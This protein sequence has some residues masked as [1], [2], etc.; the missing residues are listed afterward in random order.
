MV[1][2]FSLIWPLM[3]S[4]TYMSHLKQRKGDYHSLRSV[5]VSW[6]DVICSGIYMG[7]LVVLMEGASCTLVKD[8]TYSVVIA[9]PS[10]RCYTGLHIS[11]VVCSMVGITSFTSLVLF[12]PL[13]L[14][15][16][17]AEVV[18]NYDF[19]WLIGMFQ[20]FLPMLCLLVPLQNQSI[21][22]RLVAS[23]VTEVLFIWLF[24]S[25]SPCNILQVN[26]MGLAGFTFLL[27]VSVV[28]VYYEISRD[29]K[30]ASFTMLAASILVV[31]FSMFQRAF[32]PFVAVV[33][34]KENADGSVNNYVN[35]SSFLGKI[36]RNWFS[37]CLVI[38]NSALWVGFILGLFSFFTIHVGLLVNFVAFICAT[39]K[40]W[41]VLCKITSN[42]KGTK[43]LNSKDEAPLE[44]QRC[45]TLSD[46]RRALTAAVSRTVSA[47]KKHTSAPM[48]ASESANACKLYCCGAIRSIFNLVWNDSESIITTVYLTTFW[49]G[50]L[51]IAFTPSMTFPQYTGSWSLFSKALRFACLF[52]FPW[53]V[54]SWEFTLQ[55]IICA[56]LAAHFTYLR[57]P[58]Y[59][60][61]LSLS[62]SLQPGGML[63]HVS[64]FLDCCTRVCY[65]GILNT[66]G[67]AV[68]AFGESENSTVPQSNEAQRIS[69]AITGMLGICL[70]SGAFVLTMPLFMLTT[71]PGAVSVHLKADFLFCSGI[72]QTGMVIFISVFLSWQPFV[73]PVAS[74]VANFFIFALVWR[75]AP[76][77]NNAAVNRVLLVA[78]AISSCIS[79]CVCF[80]FITGQSD[81]ALIAALAFTATVLVLFGLMIYSGECQFDWELLFN[82][83]WSLFCHKQSALFAT[84]LFHT[85]HKEKVEVKGSS[86]GINPLTKTEHN[87][88]AQHSGQDLQ[89]GLVREDKSKTWISTYPGSQTEEMKNAFTAYKHLRLARDT[90]ENFSAFM[91]QFG[92]RVAVVYS[93][94]CAAFW[95]AGVVPVL[96]FSPPKTRSII[97]IVF[98]GVFFMIGMTQLYST[99]NQKVVWMGGD[100][101][102]GIVEIIPSMPKASAGV[103]ADHNGNEN[104]NT[105]RRKIMR[106][107]Q[108]SGKSCLSWCTF[109]KRIQIEFTN[110]KG[111]WDYDLGVPLGVVKIDAPP[112]ELVTG[113]VFLF[114]ANVMMLCILAHDRCIAIGGSQIRGYV[115]SCGLFA[116]YACLF[117]YTVLKWISMVKEETFEKTKLDLVFPLEKHEGGE[118]EEE[119]EEEE[120]QEQLE[121]GEQKQEHTQEH[122]GLSYE[123]KLELIR[124]QLRARFSNQRQRGQTLTPPGDSQTQEEHEHFDEEKMLLPDVSQAY[125]FGKRDGKDVV[126]VRF[127]DEKYC[128]MA[129]EAPGFS[130]N[131]GASDQRWISHQV[132]RTSG[133]ILAQFQTELEAT[134]TERAGGKYA[135]N[136]LRWWDY[137]VP[138]SN[139]ASLVSFMFFWANIT[140]ISF[141]PDI[142]WG[143]PGIYFG[144]VWRILGDILKLTLF[145]INWPNWNLCFFTESLCFEISA[146]FY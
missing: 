42:L 8:Q 109:W 131:E 141:V 71:H 124:E 110:T 103:A 47:L 12:R 88:E 67:Q 112:T 64:G 9:S 33:L 48:L 139:A 114:C 6:F 62:S 69:F 101:I 102:T 90:K 117:S 122:T 74:V 76:C 27:C 81:A 128:K 145:D 89:A 55:F 37:F 35:Q 68:I 36:R 115:L 34:R 40:V 11:L 24:A 118:R 113:V 146:Y 28:S 52:D 137:L 20:T 82:N 138:A 127:Q 108:A 41:K 54:S 49:G 57:V 129:F 105:C 14:A 7:V 125:T 136:P 111:T 13:F 97:L 29:V 21:W 78:F 32:E 77:T 44:K 98:M 107:M 10:I 25:Q 59:L 93:L 85:L 126:T 3:R 18:F 60:K 120:E 65:L 135:T 19:L 51:A 72:L 95:A 50:S 83:G 4:P 39:A 130:V 61:R 53:P 134:K 96:L 121:G 15:A 1:F 123:T 63:G 144:D 56:S 66:L 73:L 119:V 143:W 43:F 75:T 58:V 31:I 23:L 16:T 91:L 140:A 38:G 45:Y 84:G 106:V 133:G 17:Q 26:R 100:D 70:F 94:I 79:A 46:R 30:T 104:C 142:R 2:M 92:Q 86:V 87:E 132:V 99:I 80:V 22:V 116:D 5:K